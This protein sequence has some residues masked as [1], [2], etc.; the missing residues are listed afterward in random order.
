MK[1]NP[2][3]D[4][5]EALFLKQRK[6]SSTVTV[7]KSDLI[8]GSPD[9]EKALMAFEADIAQLITAK[10]TLDTHERA[11]D[12][13]KE[14]FFALARNKFSSL[15]DESDEV[16]YNDDDGSLGFISYDS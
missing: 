13:F 5:L 7:K 2:I 12:R 11:L 8:P 10:T 15:S 1:N 4:I 9:I 16:R 14:L 3:N 6:P